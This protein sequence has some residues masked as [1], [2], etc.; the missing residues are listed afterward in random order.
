MKVEYLMLNVG[1]ALERVPLP[2]LES[3]CPSTPF[4][5]DFFIMRR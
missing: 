2:F 3:L 1:E 4:K 5:R